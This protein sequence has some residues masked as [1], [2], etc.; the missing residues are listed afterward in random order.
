M[1]QGK[2]PEFYGAV[3]FSKRSIDVINQALLRCRQSVNGLLINGYY[4]KNVNSYR[5]NGLKVLKQHKLKIIIDPG[6]YSVWRKSQQKPFIS[7]L[8]QL[9]GNI[10]WTFHHLTRKNLGNLIFGILLPDHLMDPKD[11]IRLASQSC[12]ILI[13]KYSIP[14]DALI[15]VCHGSLPEIPT[16]KFVEDYVIQH[17]DGII[18]CCHFYIKSQG[19]MKVGLGACSAFKIKANPLNIFQRRA[20]VLKKF[21]Q[22]SK[23]KVHIHALGVG[24]KDLLDKIRDIIDSFDTQTYLTRTKVR[25]LP[26][27]ARTQAAINYLVTLRTPPC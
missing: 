18:Q 14:K 9:I 21:V 27:L 3:D 6:T 16:S 15:G 4:Y 24:T 10:V 25:R 20:E 22:T 19:L 2:S 7:F 11:T 1:T 5:E 23:S 13:K 12:S 26:G 17:L 8:P